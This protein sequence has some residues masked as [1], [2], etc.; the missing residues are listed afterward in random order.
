MYRLDFLFTFVVIFGKFIIV[1]IKVILSLSFILLV[2][3]RGPAH[4]V[5]LN[6]NL[7]RLIFIL[8]MAG[9]GYDTGQKYSSLNGFP[10]RGEFLN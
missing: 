4:D 6:R 2:Q 8:C 7:L 1:C 3:S 10:F 9:T 5:W